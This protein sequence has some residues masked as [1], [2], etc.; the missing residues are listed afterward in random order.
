M[1]LQLE[2][3]RGLNITPHHVTFRFNGGDSIVSPFISDSLNWEY[4]DTIFMASSVSTEM[5]I[6]STGAA[7]G[8]EIDNI[9]LVKVAAT[10]IFSNNNAQELLIAFPNPFADKINIIVKTNELVEVNFFDV[11]GRKI[12]Y[13][14]FRKSTSIN[15]EQLAKGVYLYEVRNKSGVIKKGKIVKD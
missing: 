14:S 13:Q 8:L 5:E 15:T 4:F 9:S 6:K 7:S 1:L 2:T 3:F 12:F 10:G 11:T